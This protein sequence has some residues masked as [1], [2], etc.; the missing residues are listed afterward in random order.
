[1]QAVVKAWAAQ[2]QEA[3]IIND[4]V[5]LN[6]GTTTRCCSRRRSR[7]VMS[8]G[9]Y[10]VCAG[11]L[12]DRLDFHRHSTLTRVYSVGYRDIGGVAVV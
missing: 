1:V 9:R 11:C 8:G 5:A 6:G 3:A 2:V 12:C 7:A 4:P 10:P